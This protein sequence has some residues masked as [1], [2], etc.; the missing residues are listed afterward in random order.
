MTKTAST[1]RHSSFPIRHFP[2]LLALLA[3]GACTP[4]LP[5][6]LSPPAPPNT[7]TFLH[8]SDLHVPMSE[9]AKTWAA[10]QSGAPP[11][12]ALPGLVGGT[13]SCVVVTG[14][15][16]EFGGASAWKDFW[17]ACTNLRLP[18]YAALGNH[19]STWRTLQPEF[20]ALY[21]GS[22]Y[23][24]DLGPARLLV[25]SS[26]APQDPRPAFT[27]E[28]LAWLEKELARE[29]AATPVIVAFH[30]SLDSG[31]FAS[32]YEGDRLLDLLAPHNVRL[33]LVGHGHAFRTH[34]WEWLTG[35]EG[36]STFGP[37]RGWNV[38][39][40]RDGRLRVAVQRAGEPPSGHLLLDEPL[41]GGRRPEISLVTPFPEDTVESGFALCAALES[42][43]EVCSAKIV[44]GDGAEAPLEFDARLS[45]Q[46]K[47]PSCWRGH[48][49]PLRG[50]PG[51]HAY[52]I[53]FEVRPAEDEATPS[54]PEGDPETP[55]SPA[56]PVAVGRSIVLRVMPAARDS[57][58]V[59]EPRWHLLLPGSIRG[60][61]EVADGGLYVATTD[62]VVHALET[63]TGRERWQTRL[64]GAC[65]GRPH[66]RPPR[67]HEG[68]EGGLFVGSLDGMVTCLDPES[69]QVRRR[70]SVGAPVAAPVIGDADRLY[71]ADLDGG[72][73]A[74]DLSGRIVRWHRQIARGAI[75]SAPVLA[76]GT[77]YVTAWDTFVYAIDAATGA[78]R[79]KAPCSSA[80]LERAAKYYSA[81]DH[82][83]IVT[84]DRVL[85]VDRGY[86]LT[87]LDRATGRE[88]TRVDDVVAV[89]TGDA[90]PG[91]A[92]DLH[93]HADHPSSWFAKR[94]GAIVRGDGPPG[95]R[96]TWRVETDIGR[97]P[98]P[99]L[100]CGDRLVTAS[101]TGEVTCRD[102][103]TGSLRWSWQATPDLY[104][105]APLTADRDT[106]YVCGMDGSV[107]ALSLGE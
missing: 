106:V 54:M 4:R 85:V 62:G 86:R 46:M 59:H 52:R 43:W 11:A 24:V 51:Y 35:I 94:G 103:A 90:G 83:P 105:M 72:L 97:M 23:S 88:V 60:A 18:V 100:V 29:G 42:G 32:R 101:S 6:L 76:D 64:G 73:T 81:A 56:P 68:D 40:L 66:F 77:L 10:L 22:S 31:E 99:P 39:E 98:A 26:A 53:V 61:A 82:T 28:T 102:S 79:W 36:G 74:L 69:G 104:V 49:P 15:C 96:E 70:M 93:P 84:A 3:T 20:T 65:L 19:D 8:A 30:H 95:S 58:A 27:V 17:R 33:A 12:M 37:E 1:V 47:P 67:P 92:P 25:L 78:E 71:V 50:G 16:T 89:A 9:S 34:R 21:G 41:A 45:M 48:A 80:T 7:L 75:E 57:A 63:A 38:I 2:A 5:S 55:G 14:D 91:L 87:V 107:T 44:A 13:P